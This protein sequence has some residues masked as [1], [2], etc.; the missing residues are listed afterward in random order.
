VIRL[1]VL[2][3]WC[4]LLSPLEL[5]AQAANLQ[6]PLDSAWML[7]DARQYDIAAEIFTRVLQ[8][9][10]SG[11]TT[12]RGFA[13]FGR[14]FA[15]QNALGSGVSSGKRPVLDLIQRD[16]QT[17]VALDS[18]RYF[19]AARHNIGL[20]YSATG[21]YRAAAD[22]FV[23]S[24]A[25][26]ADGR[27]DALVGAG[28]AWEQLGLLDSAISAY[29]QAL[30][31]DSTNA[32]AFQSLLELLA[33]RGAYSAAISLASRG[34]A[35]RPAAVLE[36]MLQVLERT[37][38]SLSPSL[39][40]SA[41]V[42]TGASLSAMY[43]DPAYFTNNLSFR[44]ALIGRIH[45]TLANPITA[46]EAAYAAAPR[47]PIRAG[48]WWGTSLDRRIVW[49]QCLRALGDWWYS[50]RLSDSVAAGFY[51]SA[52]GRPQAPRVEA[53]TPF[54]ALQPLA[55]IYATRGQSERAGAVIAAVDE[56]RRAGRLAGVQRQQLRDF[57]WAVGTQFTE[58]VQYDRAVPEL[59]KAALV[60]PEFAPTFVN[61]GYISQ[62]YGDIDEAARLFTRAIA[63]NPNEPV[64]LNNLGFISLILAD[65]RKSARLLES[66]F[67]LQRNLLTALNLG[68]AYRYAGEVDSALRW[69]RRGVELATGASLSD[70]SLMGTAWLYS[71]MPLFMGDRET[72]RRSVLVGEAG[73]KLAFVHYA[74]GLDHALAGNLPAA[75]EGFAAGWRGASTPEFR[76]F[77]ANKITAIFVW[78]RP[79]PRPA[80]WLDSKRRFLIK[81]LSCPG[82]TPPG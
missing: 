46:L 8:Q 39:R 47:F 36:A 78:L 12:T 43:V 5:R 18:A 20:V 53:W 1:E 49:S 30:R 24:A 72:I 28:R 13:H 69:H 10:R 17:A 34:L 81:E 52:I 71:Y 22:A 4:L 67:R 38:T 55:L 3:A 73:E 54:E 6:A 45:P 74:L 14:A 77:F 65:F 68:D 62:G 16:Y 40:D 42:L 7:I 44:L 80:A 79:G 56:A 51:E 15:R 41:M 29:A 27:A 37:S 63:I 33:E 48:S 19:V 58:L 32:N 76:C 57:Y 60:D 9:A 59:R 21:Q 75:E 23:A 2:A 35:G 25:A 11:D 61:L 64:A 70:R 82:T 50:R 31:S 66:S 26:S